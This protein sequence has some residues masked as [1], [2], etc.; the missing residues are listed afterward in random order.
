MVVD[1]GQSRVVD[2]VGGDQQVFWVIALGFNELG[3]GCVIDE[4]L[5]VDTPVSRSRRETRG[6]SQRKSF[7]T[8]HIV[9]YLQVHLT[10]FKDIPRHAK[11]DAWIG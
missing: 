11:I 10:P 4:D 2:T 9:V 1:P 6:Q 5:E 7:Q 8:H 3:N